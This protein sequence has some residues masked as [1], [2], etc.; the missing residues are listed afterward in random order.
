MSSYHIILVSQL[1]LGSLQSPKK[2]DRILCLFMF[3]W[4]IS[5]NS[6]GRYKMGLMMTSVTVSIATMPIAAVTVIVI[7]MRVAMASIVIRSTISSAIQ[8]MRVIHA[9]V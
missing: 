3:D 4:G 9:S 1:N 6:G 8:L 7:S 2:G 5:R